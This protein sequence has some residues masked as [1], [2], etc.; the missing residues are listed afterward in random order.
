LRNLERRA[1]AEEY[2][3]RV[4]RNSQYF[5]ELKGLIGEYKGEDWRLSISL[6]REVRL[7]VLFKNLDDEVE[8]YEIQQEGLVRRKITIKPKR[9]KLP[10][11]VS[12]NPQLEVTS[13]EDYFKS[14]G[15]VSE[16]FLDQAGVVTDMVRKRMKELADVKL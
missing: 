1:R 6:D 10:S 12:F 16:D 8:L 3:R 15:I 5:S 14:F 9:I 4:E 2:E 7:K 13:D 11:G